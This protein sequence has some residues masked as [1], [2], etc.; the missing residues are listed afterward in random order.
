MSRPQNVETLMSLAD[1]IV[2][3][4]ANYGS[5][6][7]TEESANDIETPTTTAKGDGH[8]VKMLYTTYTPDRVVLWTYDL[9]NTKWF[10]VEML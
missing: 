2:W 6:I 5:V 4:A 3:A 10:G 7:D 9:T 8:L 1:Q